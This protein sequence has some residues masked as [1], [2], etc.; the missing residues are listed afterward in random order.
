MVLNELLGLYRGTLLDDVIP[1]WMKHGIDPNGG[2]NSCIRDNGEVVSR[3][4]WSR[5]QTRA[6][7]VFSKLYNRIEPRSEWLDIAQGIYRFVT[8]H[9]PLEDGTWPL[10]LS[11]DGEVLRGHESVFTDTFAIYGFV[12]LWR[13]TRN[14]EALDLAVNTFRVLEKILGSQEPPPTWPYPTPPGCAAHAVSM[15]CSLVYNELADATKDPATRAAADEHHRRVMESF[16]RENRG[17]LL[18]LVRTDGTELET[19]KGR[20]VVPGH[21]IE[22]MWF[23]MLIARASG[24]VKTLDRCVEVIHR[25]L[26]AGWDT[27]YGG[28]LLAVDADGNPDVDWPHADSKVWWPQTE[29]LVATLLAYEH[30]GE[31]WCLDWHEKV[32]DYAYSRYPVEVYG[33]WTQELNRK[34]EAS[35]E[36]VGLPVKDPFHLPRALMYC[37]DILERLVNKS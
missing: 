1:F 18:E 4:R 15:M 30:C 37:I 16:Y 33:E 27:E 36:L 13:A 7:Y 23:Q 3:D 31:Q 10:L 5:S 24:N 6:I 17:L 34:G 35:T 26:E 19:P 12:E 25:H 2:I 32:R 8:A 28:I 22:S 9:G 14:E 21:A 29:A 20:A 11:G